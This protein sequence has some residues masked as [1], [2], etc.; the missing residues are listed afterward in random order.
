MNYDQ[1]IKV[2]TKEAPSGA[3]REYLE[4]INGLTH[5]KRPTFSHEE[6]LDY[7]AHLLLGLLDMA[8]ARRDRI[9]AYF[10]EMAYIET[11]DQLRALHAKR[12]RKLSAA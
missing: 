5:A 12:Q 11:C 9:R 2:E 1:A 10:I 7:T 3:E 8:K 6:E 4:A